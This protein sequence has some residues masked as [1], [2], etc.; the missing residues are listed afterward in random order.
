LP[1]GVLIGAIVRKDVVLMPA[2]EI[3]IIPGDHII[4]MAKAGKS[5][6]VEHLFTVQ[7]DL[8]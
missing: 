4:V 6:E 5:R 3:K 1:D 7:V 8:F 2:P